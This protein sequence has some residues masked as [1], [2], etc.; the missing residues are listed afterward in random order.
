MTAI[1]CPTP[2]SLQE[3]LW[4]HELPNRRQKNP[5]PPSPEKII[6]YG[7][8]IGS[9]MQCHSSMGRAMEQARQHIVNLEEAG[10]SAA[11]GTVILADTLIHSK[12]RFARTWH[13]PPGGLWGCIILA[14]TFMPRARTLLPLALGVACC[15]AV[16]DL[17]AKK[18][19]VRW[20]NDV[21]VSGQKIGGFL[22]ESF[23]SPRY[24]EGYHLLGFGINI[25]NNCF[26]ETLANMAVSLSHTLGKPVNLHDFTLSF[27][28]KMTWNIGLL[29]YEEE[30][31]LHCDCSW[32]DSGNSEEQKNH[33]LLEQWKNLSDTL[34]RRVLYGYDI[35]KKP[36]YEARVTGIRPDGAIVMRLDDGNQI[37]EHSG[38]LQYL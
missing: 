11:S 4:K 10:G 25:N 18:A 37:I 34:G 20:V 5:Q 31:E 9:V 35:Q 7:A 29:C 17:G 6:R 23:R 38:E 32:K 30:Q 12:G 13:A 14:D 15:E 33:L 16:R 2:A 36:Q 8:I 24:G 28:A 26:P 22:V 27:L 3:Y 1:N 19:C 21:L